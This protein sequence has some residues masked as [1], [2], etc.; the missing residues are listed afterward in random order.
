MHVAEENQSHADAAGKAAFSGNGADFHVLRQG[1]QLFRLF[2][3]KASQLLIGRAVQML[4]KPHLQHAA[5]DG[6]LVKDVV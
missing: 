5:G 6:N 3:A 1:D 4:P 2:Q